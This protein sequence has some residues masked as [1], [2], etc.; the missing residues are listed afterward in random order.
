LLVAGQD[1]KTAQVIDSI[2]EPVR[3]PP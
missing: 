1:Q 3:L 2:G